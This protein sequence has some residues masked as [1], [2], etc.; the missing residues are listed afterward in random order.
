MV[1]LGGMAMGSESGGMGAAASGG[2]GGNPLFH[3]GFGLM[4]MGTGLALARNAG[5]KVFAEVQRRAFATLEVTS[6]D[7]GYKWIL[8]WIRDRGGNSRHLSLETKFRSFENGRVETEFTYVPAVGAHFLSYR[9]AWFKVTRA[10]EKEMVDLTSGS[11][12]ESVVLT[13]RNRNRHLFGELLNEAK[14][15]SLKQEAGKTVIYTALMTEWK[16]FG[17]P[18]RRRPLNSVMLA[19]TTA[20]KLVDDVT[21]FS[22]SAK[23][24]VDRGIPFRRGYLLHGPPG[25]GKTSFI[26]ALAGHLEYNVCILNLNDKGLTD[27]RLN[28]LMAVLPPHSIVLLEDIDAA[29]VKRDPRVERYSQSVSFSGLLNMLDGAASTERRLVF[30]TTNHIELLDPALMRPG[31]VDVIEYIGQASEDQARNLFLKFF[32]N[33]TQLAAEFGKIMGS[34]PLASMAQLQGYLMLYKKSPPG[35]VKYAPRFRDA[36]KSHAVEEAQSLKQGASDE[37]EH[38]STGGDDTAALAKKT[39]VS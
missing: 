34:E 19:G 8:Q 36:L 27:D 21:E 35:A 14:Q 31:R 6:K 18:R 4:L 29:F 32:D 15:M 1:G 11:P 5:G 22:S 10:R 2:L 33:E 20:Q 3:A 24:Y 12:W 17:N 30:M 39:A 38:T 26:M 16:V 7:P 37:K 23:W 13:T 28:H 9:G 25:C